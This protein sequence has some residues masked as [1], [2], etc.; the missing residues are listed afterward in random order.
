MDDKEIYIQVGQ[1]KNGRFVKSEQYT[2]PEFIK[3]INLHVDTKKL[4]IEPRA[5]S[6]FERLRN[7]IVKLAM[8]EA[9]VKGVI[10]G[11]TLIVEQLKTDINEIVR[12]DRPGKKLK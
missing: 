4:Q 8:K 11:S 10:I 9:V 12:K 2:I 3:A 7:S 6:F 5:L 1:R